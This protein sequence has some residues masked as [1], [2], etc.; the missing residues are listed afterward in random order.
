MTLKELYGEGIEALE[1]ADVESPEVDAFYLLQ[2]VTGVDRAHYLL[3]KDRT[4][5]EAAVE[6]YMTLI[7]RRAAHEPYQYITGETEFMGYKI[8]VTPDV[9]IP[10]LDSEVVC[11]EALKIIKADDTVLDM[12]TGSG[13]LAIAIKKERASAQVWASDISQAALE[14]AKENAKINEADI[15]FCKGDLF[16]AING[17]LRFDCVISNPPYVTEDEYKELTLEVRDNEPKL[18]LTAGAEGLDIY[19]RLV[20]E[21]FHRLKEGGHLVMEMGC[22]Q[23]IALTALMKDAGYKNIRVIKDLAGLDRAVLGE[24]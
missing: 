5:T 13:C 10:R 22:S 12:C 16:E 21:A 1:F 9:L 24:R 3:D 17:D 6:G 2:H 8:K 4:V 15:S 19:E 23:G 20:P 11:E 14:V 7:R 18:A